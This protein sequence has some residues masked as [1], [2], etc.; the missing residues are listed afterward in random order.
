MS[1]KSRV[2]LCG[3][4]YVTRLAQNLGVFT[5]LTGLTRSGHMLEIAM[6]TFRLMHL[7]EKRR[8][9]YVLLEGDASVGGRAAVAEEHDV[10]IPDILEHPVQPSDVLAHIEASQRRQ[11]ETQCRHEVMLRHLRSQLDWQQQ[12]MM[13]LLL[14]R[15]MDPPQMLPAPSAFFSDSLEPETSFAPQTGGDDLEADI[16]AADAAD[17]DEEGDDLD[18]TNDIDD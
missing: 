17:A 14:E 5:D 4:S 11:E 9:D 8:D 2:A 1:N 13:M 10:P 3:G 16:N 12:C 6:D 15:G 7:V 18:D